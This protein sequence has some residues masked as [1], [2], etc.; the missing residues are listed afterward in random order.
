MVNLDKPHKDGTMKTERCIIV[1][2][3]NS[4][5]LCS[6]WLKEWGILISENGWYI[7]SLEVNTA[8]EVAWCQ[9]MWE[10]NDE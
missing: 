10:D 3:V 8:I 7:S 4:H 6:I 5:S 9:V 2:Y 1:V